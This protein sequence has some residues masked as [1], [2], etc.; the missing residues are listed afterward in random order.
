MC[1]RD[2]RRSP[3]AITHNVSTTPPPTHRLLLLCVVI[4]AA[5]G[6]N[7]GSVRYDAAKH[8]PKKS[9]GCGKDSPYAVGVST[10]AKGRYDGVEW[11]YRVRLPKGYDKHT[12][13]PLIVHHPGW[14]LTALAE[15][16]G[17]GIASYADELGFISVTAQ[18]MN[19]NDRRGGPWYSWNCVG[20]T[21]SPGPRGATCTDAANHMSYCYK[22]C[23]ERSRRQRLMTARH[24]NPMVAKEQLLEL[25]R[26]ATAATYSYDDSYSYGGG[27]GG[28]GKC[29]DQPQ[30]WWTT[31]D[32]TVTPT[33]TGRREATGF[34]PSLFDTLE[35]QLCIDVTREYASGESNGGMQ[36]Y[37]LGVDLA[38]RLAA[39][40]PEFGSFHRGFAMSPSVGVALLDLHGSHDRTVPANV[41]LS[42][43]GYHYVTTKEILEGTHDSKG[44][45]HANG[46]SGPSRHW[47][48]EW[49]GL[50]D[51]WCIEEGDCAGG[52]IVRCMWKGG[53]NWLFNDARANGGLVTQFLLQWTKPSHAGR[54]A[55]S[56][57]SGRLQDGPPPVTRLL[58]P[59][60]ILGEADDSPGVEEAFDSL[61]RT[62]QPVDDGHVEDAGGNDGYVE[63]AGGSADEPGQPAASAKTPMA[64]FATGGWRRVKPHYSDPKQ[65][66]RQDEDEVPA[67]S[68]SVCAYKIGS[69]AGAGNATSGA[70]ANG[71]DAALPEP[72][73]K[74]GGATPSMNG[75]PMDAAV[76]HLSRAWPICLAKSLR[77]DVE[78][79]Y[80][81]GDFHCLLVCPCLGRGNACSE[82]SHR[83]CPWGARCERGELRNRAHGVCTYY[84]ASEWLPL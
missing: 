26:N 32:E 41:S 73:C 2:V 78:N 71:E 8:E 22:S 55:S 15:E 44:W 14:G 66:C 16:T 53:H 39:I 17:A 42:A 40:A 3:R 31:C 11:T 62:L 76:H 82:E 33:G 48:T 64:T 80:R 5:E 46:C 69:R 28:G 10:A 43:D 63:D 79:P 34:I 75:C 58:A 19:D 21:Q 45:K 74:L 61:P 83:H 6:N 7:H 49:D 51:F 30:C 27:G 12:P 35:E 9:T 29:G 56:A 38:S 77:P 84:R 50:R 57:G 23:Q 60:A 37:Q 52:G 18:G 13:I 20:S 68:G 25:K 67:G 70:E 24:G 65:G 36:T 47:P 59:M 72:H 1:G 81:R 4:A 54:G